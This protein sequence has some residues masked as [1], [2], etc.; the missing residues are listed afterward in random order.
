M[1]HQLHHALGDVKA[2]VEVL[3]KVGEEKGINVWDFMAEV[4]VFGKD[5]FGNLQIDCVQEFQS[6]R[7][8]EDQLIQYLKSLKRTHSK[9]Y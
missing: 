6:K 5:P 9:K 8:D 7:K 4:F 2:M 3:N 1:N